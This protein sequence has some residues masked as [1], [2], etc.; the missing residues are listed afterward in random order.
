MSSSVGILDR[1][2]IRYAN[3]SFYYSVNETQ[4]NF[5]ALQVGF[6]LYFR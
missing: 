4:I 5:I 2:S 1:Q 3:D 6:V